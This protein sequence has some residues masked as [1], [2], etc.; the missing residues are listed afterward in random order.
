MFP[1]NSWEVSMPLM[2]THLSSHSFTNTMLPCLLLTYFFGAAPTLS[3]PLRLS[4]LIPIPSST[5]NLNMTSIHVLGFLLPEKNTR[6]QFRWDWGREGQML[7]EKI[8]KMT[9]S[10]WNSN[11]CISLT[12]NA[13]SEVIHVFAPSAYLFYP[14]AYSHFDSRTALE[15]KNVSELPIFYLVAAIYE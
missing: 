15:C 7:E 11:F 6:N 3:S 5:P 2:F 13:S 9:N 4:V 12:M 1:T 14:S 10:T 8:K